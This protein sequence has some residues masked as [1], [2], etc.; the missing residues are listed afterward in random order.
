M[1]TV[2]NSTTAQD[3]K[4]RADIDRS[5]RHPVMFFFTSGA[6][7]LAASLILWLIASIKTHN[8]SFLECI[9]FFN[10]G[11]LNAAYES[12]FVYGW[13]MQAAF[14]TMIWLMARLSRQGC[15]SGGLILAA[16]HVWNLA[17]AVGVLNL[18]VGSNTDWIPFMEGGTGKQWMFPSSVMWTL[19]ITYVFI[20]IWSFINFRVRRGG[21]VYVS[22][23]YILAALFWFPWVFLTAHTFVNVF[24]GN[25]VLAAGI[26]AWFRY[27]LIFLFFTPVAVASA[28]YLAPKVT[29][30]PV[31]SYSLALFGFWTLAVVGPW[32]GMHRLMGAPIPT[33]LQYT[34]AAAVIFFLVPAIAVAVNI[35]RTTSAHQAKVQNSPSLRFTIAGVYGMLLTG[36]IGLILALPS[37]A[38]LAQFTMAQRGYEMMALYGFFSMCM[39]GAIY[40]IVP[41]ITNREWLSSRFI[42]SHFYCSLYGVIFCAIFVGILGGFMEGIGQESYEESWIVPAKRALAYHWSITIAIAFILIANFFFCVHLLLM[43]LRL[44]RRSSHPTLL[45]KHESHSPHGSDA[46]LEEIAQA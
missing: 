32:A 20:A 12:G 8:P 16:G 42:R 11:R 30:R 21:H 5:L 24:D 27:A 2:T 44:G 22:Q 41:R 38:K 14:G 37:V 39:F 1:A 10:T 19:L 18:L 25:P 7:W 43:W 34:G 13:C 4:L 29:G 9:P 26:N 35:I 3:V 36:L 23:W 31:Y 40:F 45:H 17:V 15:K 6:A 46:T 33:L 28:Y